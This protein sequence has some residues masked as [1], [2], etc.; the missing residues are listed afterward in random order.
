MGQL[1]FFYQLA[2][3]ILDTELERRW[4]CSI[5]WA[6]CLLCVL[7]WLDGW[8]GLDGRSTR[9]LYSKPCN[10]NCIGK[11]IRSKIFVTYD[12]GK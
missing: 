2:G 10:C 8:E 11:H 5:G 12:M 9:Y 7:G 1:V 3:G 4:F 6:D